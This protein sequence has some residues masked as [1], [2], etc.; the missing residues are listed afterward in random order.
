MKKTLNVGVIGL[1][2]LGTLYVEY[3][4]YQIPG[5]EVIAVVDAN[6]ERASET[7]MNHNVA[8]TFSDHRDLLNLKEIDAVVIVSPTGTHRDIVVDAAAAG[9]MI[10][11]EKP[12]SISLDEA[13]D[14]KKAVTKAGV[15][16][17][18]GFMRRFDR[19]YAAAK[20]RILEGEIGKPIVFK[21]TSRDPFRP[22]LEYA[23][24][25]MSGGL[26]LDMG[27]HDFDLA[28]WFMGDVA[29]VYSL[30]KVLA[31]PEMETIN[32][33]DNAVVT[34]NFESGTIGM[35]DMTRSGIYG[36]DIRTE[37]LGTEGTIQI[38]YLRETPITILK[39]E[40]VSHDTVPYFME[41]FEESYIIQLKDFIEKAHAQQEPSVTIEDGERALLVGHAAT[42]SLH[43][44]M[45]VAINNQ[46][47]EFGVITKTESEPIKN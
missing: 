36:Y 22:S 40:G 12:L 43:Q 3:L 9:K 30:G 42:H 5:A 39:K 46:A 45:P 8:H 2:R 15:F 16:F 33:I 38:G 25:K 31:Y 35:A 34:L 17:H 14:M 21:A 4:Q 47:M 6:N 10:F 29:E 26:L 24:P 19:G 44:K 11:C 32:D 27:I 1:G 28:R 41:R 37:I 7:A 18:M 23:D 13:A 20:K